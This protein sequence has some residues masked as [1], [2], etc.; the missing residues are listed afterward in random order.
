MPT[1][2]P[3]RLDADDGDYTRLNEA[4]CLGCHGR[5]NAEHKM[6]ADVHRDEYG[7]VCMDC[8]TEEG[9][10]GDDNAYLAMQEA[11]VFKVSCSNA[12]CHQ[13]LLEK[14]GK[15]NAAN[16]KCFYRN[17]PQTGFKLLLNHHGKVRTASYQSLTWGGEIAYRRQRGYE[18]I[19]SDLSDNGQSVGRRRGDASGTDGHYPGTTWGVH[20]METVGKHMPYGT[21][22]TEEQ[23]N[24]LISGG[25]N[26][27]GGID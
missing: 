11:G 6:L 10:H 22:L 23:M 27:A 15:E 5:Q 16:G 24:R 25:G 8:H 20:E 3:C 13:N 18:G 26:S 19:P 17:I 12:G 1:D 21:P 2:N 9:V 7:M 4:T 14:P